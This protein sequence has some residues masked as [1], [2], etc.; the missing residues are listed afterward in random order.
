M[1]IGIDFGTSFSLPAGLINGHLETLLPGGAYG[2][3]WSFTTI[4]MPEF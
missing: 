2:V 3:P 1:K 4:Q